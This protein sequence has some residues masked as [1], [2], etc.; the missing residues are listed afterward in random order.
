MYVPKEFA[1][2]FWDTDLTGFDSQR[3]PDYTI[4]RVLEHGNSD[5]VKWLE[6]AFPRDEICRVLR[7]ERRLTPKSANFWALV[8][9]VPPEE[10][11]AL[12]AAPDHKAA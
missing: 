3:Y 7:S 5:A 9:G 1:A 10:V 2:L 6:S 8:Y 11:A 12:R 4:F